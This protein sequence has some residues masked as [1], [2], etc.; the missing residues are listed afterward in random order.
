MT[1]AQNVA[2]VVERLGVLPDGVIERRIV[3]FVPL[4][5][6]S[7]PKK[8]GPMTSKLPAPKHALGRLEGA[9]LTLGPI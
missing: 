3:D 2:I 8:M 5:T 1:G 9:N 7:A 4:G 6:T